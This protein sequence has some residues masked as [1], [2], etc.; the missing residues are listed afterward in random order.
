MDVQNSGH[1]HR[2]ESVSIKHVQQLLSMA[3]E[4]IDLLE[5]VPPDAESKPKEDSTRPASAA[6]EE[7]VDMDKERKDE[8][9]NMAAKGDVDQI[10]A[11][12]G[13]T[14]PEIEGLS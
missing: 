5:D 7:P 12:F 9:A 11:S 1:I 13:D 4:D 3:D 8:I 2:K 6:Q 14:L 10:I